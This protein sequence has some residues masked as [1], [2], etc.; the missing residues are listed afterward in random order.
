V[1]KDKQDMKKLLE[2]GE[3]LYGTGHMSEFNQRASSWYSKYAALKFCK[4]KKTY[5]ILF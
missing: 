3:P 5:F 4:Y 1:E 2:R